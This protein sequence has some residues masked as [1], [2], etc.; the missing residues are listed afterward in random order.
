MPNDC[1]IIYTLLHVVLFYSTPIIFWLIYKLIYFLLSKA[2]AALCN[3][4]II[5]HL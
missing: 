5:E 1:F 3:K 4:Q 2:E